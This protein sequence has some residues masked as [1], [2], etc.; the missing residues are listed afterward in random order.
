MAKIT[1]DDITSSYASTS[2]FQANF[3]AI[4]TEF[5]DKVLYRVNPV[6]E[7]N[8]M[9]NDLDMNSNSILNASTINTDVIILNGLPITAGGNA[10]T[11]TYVSTEFTNVA[12]DTIFNCDYT[13]G[14]LEVFYNGVLLSD[15]NFTALDGTTVTLTTPVTDN[16]DVITCKAYSSFLAADMLQKSLNLSD[17]SDVPTARTSLGLG[18]AALVDHGTASTEVP[19]N[20]DLG[21]ASLVDTGTGATQVPTNADVRNPRNRIV[22]PSMAISQENGFAAQV[23]PSNAAFFLADQVATYTESSTGAIL[24]SSFQTLEGERSVRLTAATAATDLSTTK[25]GGS[26]LTSLEKSNMHQLNGGDVVIAFTCNTNWTGKLS[27]AVRSLD[28]ARTYVTDVDVVSGVNH[29]FKVIP[30][31]ADTVPSAIAENANA[32]LVYVG[33]NNEG[34][35]QQLAADN[36]AWQA[37]ASLTSDESTQW[38]KTINNYVEITNVDLY[39]GNVPREFQP[40]SYAYDLAECER[41]Y[42]IT[43][44]ANNESMGLTGSMATTTTPIFFGLFQPEMRD[45]PLVTA[46]NI[47]ASSASGGIIPITAITPAG[48]TKA[49]YRVNGTTVLTLSAGTFVFLRASV[50]ESHIAFNARL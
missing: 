26:I 3:T 32:V 40:N 45:T 50:A 41:Y 7:A 23:V 19:L 49:A 12:G 47:N 33:Y 16:A 17:L 34:T 6:G 35:S 9:K 42:R 29:V 4:E 24:N 30:F 48:S 11:L 14:F 36:D 13:V 21:S 37:G 1:L 8:Q 39:A 22:N 18:T 31:E 28:N 44:G 25:A 15:A 27:V 5:N 46:L 2:L 43:R 20:S 10:T 38:T